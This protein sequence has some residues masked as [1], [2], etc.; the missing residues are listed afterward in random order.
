MNKLFHRIWTNSGLNDSDFC[1]SVELSATHLIITTQNFP[2][3]S[4]RWQTAHTAPWWRVAP[5]SSMKAIRH[6]VEFKSRWWNAFRMRRKSAET[7]T[8]PPLVTS[9]YKILSDSFSHP[10]SCW[11]EQCLHFVWCSGA[12]SLPNSNEKKLEICQVDNFKWHHIIVR[13]LQ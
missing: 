4:M 2:P 12:W 8:M 10:S 9:R 11:L 7:K 3:T 13:A 5:P 1:Y 6:A